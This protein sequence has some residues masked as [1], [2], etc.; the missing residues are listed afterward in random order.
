MRDVNP[1]AVNFL[2]KQDAR[3]NM[4]HKSLDCLFRDL[5]TKNVDTTLQHAQPFTKEDKQ[6]LWETGV[7]GIVVVHS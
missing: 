2:N 3:F 5:R 7:L 6:L 1:N 4:F